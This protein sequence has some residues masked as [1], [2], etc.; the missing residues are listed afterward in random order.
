LTS[1]DVS[2]GKLASHHWDHISYEAAA[3]LLEE[4]VHVSAN[5]AVGALQSLT[6]ITLH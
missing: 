6:I 2:P 3:G 4:M 5:V 1:S